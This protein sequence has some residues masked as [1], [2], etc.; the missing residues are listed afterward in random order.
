M[1]DFQETAALVIEHRVKHGKERVYEQWLAEILDVVKKVPGYL[2]REIFTPNGKGKPYVTI[3]RFES[4]ET[5]ENWLAS[6][7]RKA[8]IGKVRNLLADGEKTSVKAGI[9][10]W[11]LSCDKGRRAPAYK[12]FL[13]TLAAIYPITLIV[14][15]L[16]S[17]I[18]NAIPWLKETFLG[19]LL[20]SAV[21]VGLMTYLIMPRLTLWFD[22][23]L[24]KR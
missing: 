12:Q 10:V 24:Y 17:P 11:F 2:G 22:G 15:Q 7:E 1:R 5:L 8:I 4:Q 14:P 6:D 19:G 21:T 23:W 18:Q 20:V 13:L 16:L 3:V 9:D